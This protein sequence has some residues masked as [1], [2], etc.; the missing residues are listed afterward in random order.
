MKQFSQQI[1]E[2]KNGVNQ[3]VDYFLCWAKVPSVKAKRVHWE[4]PM[5][6]V[7]Y[8]AIREGGDYGQVEII[9]LKRYVLRH[10]DQ[11]YHLR[12]RPSMARLCNFPRKARN[13]D[14]YVKSTDLSMLEMKSNLSMLQS[15]EKHTSGL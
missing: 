12:M 8:N 13:S 14:L 2:L 4:K 7:K 1:Y 9:L 11:I 10:P 3:H 15:Q 5:T 6:W